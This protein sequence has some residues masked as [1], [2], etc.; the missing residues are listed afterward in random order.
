MSSSTDQSSPF[1]QVAVP[2]PLHQ[3]F[4]YRWKGSLAP[5]AGMRVKIPFGRRSVIGIVVCGIASSS[6]PLNKL[7]AVTEV[8]D[9]APLLPE[10][11]F[12]KKPATTQSMPQR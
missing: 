6:F 3:L 2:T 8:L 7:R 4:D 12:C 10:D 1:V 9:E 11:K 5:V